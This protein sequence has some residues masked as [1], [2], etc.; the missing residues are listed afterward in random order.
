MSKTM[1]LLEVYVWT[2]GT[3]FSPTVLFVMFQKIMIGFSVT[4]SLIGLLTL[5]GNGFWIIP[6]EAL[7]Q[8]GE[9]FFLPFLLFQT[10][11]VFLAI[12]NTKE[13]SIQ[14]AVMV[15]IL[16][17]SVAIGIRGWIEMEQMESDQIFKPLLLLAVGQGIFSVSYLVNLIFPESKSVNTQPNKFTQ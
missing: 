5:L 1:V 10:A 14:V 6:K 2:D 7:F 15:S 12:A 9:N 8:S 3:I 4:Y 17:L 13:E 16:V 11:L